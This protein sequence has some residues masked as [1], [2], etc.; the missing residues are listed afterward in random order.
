MEKILQF[1]HARYSFFILVIILFGNCGDSSSSSANDSAKPTTDKTKTSSNDKKEE[2]VLEKNEAEPFK[3]KDMLYAWVDKLNI[4]DEASLKGKTINSV[5]SNDALEFTGEKSGNT[6]TIVLRGVAY[7]DLWYKIITNDDQEGWVFGGAVKR[8]KEEKGNAPITE[9]DFEFP[10]F[11]K[12]ALSEWKKINSK[13]EGEEVDVEITTYQKG[14]QFL[15]I[16][17]SSMGE[18]HYGYI[19]KLM[20]KTKNLLKE[21]SFSFTGDGLELNESVKDFSKKTEYKRSQ[22]LEKHF[23]QLN[24]KPLMVN[25]VWSFEKLAN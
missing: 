14:D 10:H 7:Q 9:T 20:D 22:K 15:E 8:K 24:A 4:R 23:Y 2:T 6:E 19:H 18:F 25:G 12:F 16:S 3:E 1:Q 5:N 11:G 21:R 17:S 13:S